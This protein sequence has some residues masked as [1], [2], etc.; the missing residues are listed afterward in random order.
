MV[1]WSSVGLLFTEWQD[2]INVFREDGET[3]IF[4]TLVMG[5]ETRRGDLRANDLWL[6]ITH[7][8]FQALEVIKR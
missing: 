3:S 5:F 2:H 7:D 6:D 8:R 4:L 1:L